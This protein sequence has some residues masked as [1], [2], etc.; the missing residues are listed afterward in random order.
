VEL[1][2]APLD[3]DVLAALGAIALVA[4]VVAKHVTRAPARPSALVVAMQCSPSSP[5]SWWPRRSTRRGGQADMPPSPCS[6]EPSSIREGMHRVLQ[7]AQRTFPHARGRP[8]R[9]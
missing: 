3:L 5:R 1:G 7:R 9:A 2:A 6:A 4:A 8:T